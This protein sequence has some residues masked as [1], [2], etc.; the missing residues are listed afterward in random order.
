VG[1]RTEI[2][3]VSMLGVLVLGPQRLHT[4][5]GNVA[6][7]KAPKIRHSHGAG[8]PLPTFQRGWKR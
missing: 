4:M 5:L 7:A 3:F 8:P 2:L 6:R 1:A